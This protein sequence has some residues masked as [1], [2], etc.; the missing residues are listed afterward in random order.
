MIRSVKK[1]IPLFYPHCPSGV[2]DKIEELF[3]K[4]EIT[5]GKVSEKFEKLLSKYLK[6]PNCVLLNSCTS[7][8]TLA[9]R[10][11]NLKRGDEVITTPYTCMATNEPLYNMEINFKFADIEKETGNL[12]PKSIK[13]NLTNKTKAIV[14]THWA[15]Q[16]A[17]ILAIKKIIGKKKIKIIEDAAH[18]FGASLINKKIGNHGDFVCFS[19]Q[20]IK[21]FTTGDGG[22]LVCKK[23]SDA[24]RA[25][26]LRWFGLSRN[27]K[28]N[29]WNQDIKES[30]YKF[31]M[32]NLV[33]AIGVEQ[34]KTIKKKIAGHI[35]NGLLFDKKI[36]NSKIYKIKRLEKST[37]SY[38]VYTI[39]VKNK[40]N[41][42]KY[43]TNNGVRVD[44]INFRNDRYSVFKKFKKKLPNTKF[45]DNRAI[46]IPVGWWLTNQ[47]K[48]KI[49]Y[50][51]N[52]YNV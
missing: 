44:E 5:E 11:C 6:N 4:G 28:G 38:W 19:F 22:L 15:G 26:L 51:C 45:F 12:C 50:L 46:N 31:H 35:K 29:K 25:K 41:F 30:G 52:N 1:L 9:Y 21:H 48:K 14:V 47:Q 49:I 16:P 2:G 10:L 8:L 36:K 23:K 3:K 13:E 20:A 7:A 34:M 32:N 37:S 43:M 42:M 40:L 33:A 17:N 27:Y 39:L 24:A 18:A